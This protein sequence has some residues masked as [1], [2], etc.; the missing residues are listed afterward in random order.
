MTKSN[1]QRDSEK[2]A[3]PLLKMLTAHY[4]TLVLARS[5]ETILKQYSALLRFLRSQPDDF[6]RGHAPTSRHNEESALLPVLLEQG[7][8]TASLDDLQSFVT[9][10]QVPRKHLERVAIE[11]FSVPRGSMRSYSN[12]QML[13]EKLLSLIDNERAHQIIGAVARGQT[14]ELDNEAIAPRISG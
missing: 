3:R 4:N 7:L 5:D 14:K 12:R 6:L 13:V 8:Q 10:E 9:D 2:V 1:R 11:R